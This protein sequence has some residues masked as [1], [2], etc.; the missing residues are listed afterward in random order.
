M[1]TCYDLKS[2]KSQNS[3]KTFIMDIVI[4]LKIFS[5][6]SYKSVGTFMK[7]IRRPKWKQ[8]DF[9]FNLEIL[10][11]KKTLCRTVLIYKRCDKR[12]LR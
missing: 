1:L 8:K 12:F 3:Q 5:T 2:K 9:F 7:L 4:C 6:K 11:E 10:H